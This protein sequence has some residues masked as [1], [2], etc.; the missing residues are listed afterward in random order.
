MKQTSNKWNHVLK[1][2]NMPTIKPNK[3]RF[4][5]HIFICQKWYQN[6]EIDGVLFQV[7]ENYHLMVSSTKK[8]IVGLSDSKNLNTKLEQTYIRFILAHWGHKVPL[9]GKTKS[10]WHNRFWMMHNKV[11]SSCQKDYKFERFTKP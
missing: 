1:F 5:E 4:H 2:G 3:L 10:T 9:K 8:G 11:W 6:V 7:I